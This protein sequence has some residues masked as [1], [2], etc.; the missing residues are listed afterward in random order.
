MKKWN[1]IIVFI[2]ILIFNACIKDESKE[3]ENCILNGVVVCQDPLWKVP[4]DIENRVFATIKPYYT[5]DGNVIVGTN[6]A[7]KFGLRCMEIETG[8]I[9]WEHFFNLTDEYLIIRDT[10]FN[11]EQKFL[12]FSLGHWGNIKHIKLDVNTGE[13]LWESAIETFNTIEAYGDHYYC[14]VRSSGD[15]H[16]IYKVS[17]ATGQ[18]EYYYETDL[19]PDPDYN[20]QRSNGAYP[21]EYNGKECLFIGIMQMASPNS[22]NYY[23]SLIDANTQ[24]RLLKHVPIESGL[25]KVDVHAEDIYVFTGNGYKI[26]NFETLSFEKEIK[27]LDRGEYVYHIFYKDKLILGLDYYG[28]DGYDDN[29]QSHTH[30]IIDVN[31]HTKQ[32]GIDDINVDPA[33][34]MD[35]ILYF[36][37]GDT[38]YAYNINTGKC[39][40]KFDPSGWETSFCTATYK[41]AKGEKFVIVDD[42]RH[43]YCYEG[44]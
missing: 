26:F 2:F 37:S 25:E 31:T 28:L 29:G 21:F 9:I 30:F 42:T 33:S 7:G 22:A 4:H 16:Q 8:H 39:V 23:Y 38:Y 24:E 6:K 1:L 13:I 19:P 34:V 40:L 36:L 5:F 20:A 27:L 3:L 12:V 15:V 41:N 32:Y 10:Y 14:T 17:I 11:A 18:A 44:I 35:D 43:T